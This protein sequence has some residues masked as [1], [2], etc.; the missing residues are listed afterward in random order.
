MTTSLKIAAAAVAGVALGTV[1]FS[2]NAHDGHG[3]G[4]HQHAKDL[5]CAGLKEWH[6]KLTSNVED[7]NRSITNHDGTEVVPYDKGNPDHVELTR[8]LIQQGLERQRQ[9]GC[10]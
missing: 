8:I 2:A 4:K 1:G 9:L 10:K 6:R 7:P 5:D 3:A